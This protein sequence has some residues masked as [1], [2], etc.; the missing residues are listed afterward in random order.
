MLR[1][2]VPN[3]QLFDYCYGSTS[4]LSSILF[5]IIVQHRATFTNITFYRLREG[6]FVVVDQ[7]SSPGSSLHRLQHRQNDVKT[8]P[9][10]YELPAR[11]KT[12][13]ARP[14]LNRTKNLY[15]RNARKGFRYTDISCTINF[16]ANDFL[17]FKES[18]VNS[19]ITDSMWAKWIYRVETFFQQTVHMRLLS[20]E[21]Q[22]IPETN[23]KF[24]RL[25]HRM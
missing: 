22:D 3:M 11:N 5:W 13:R 12:N 20:L 6:I 10:N 1:R 7:P 17:L 14:R 23:R 24:L 9:L 8:A 18:K 19:T 16:I 25:H 4:P 2:L 21:S 15:M